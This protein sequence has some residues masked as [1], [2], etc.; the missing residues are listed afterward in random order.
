MPST[1]GT[2]DDVNPDRL[3]ALAELQGL[4][5]PATGLRLLEL[6]REVPK[7]HAIV[8]L[9]A[10]K[11]KSTC[12]LAEGAR[13]GNGAHVF[14]IDAWDLPTNLRGKHGY[15]D[16][17]TYRRY[18][19]QIADMELGAYITTIQA[20][21]YAPAEGW[22]QPVGLL[23]IDASHEFKDVRHDYLSWERHV[24]DGGIVAFDDYATRRNPG[25]TKWVDH[26]VRHD[27]TMHFWDT[28]TLPLAIARKRR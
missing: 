28:R 2:T 25:V 11:G 4:I 13:L 15:T 16:P 9:G 23:F 22:G 19:Q 6:A 20:L 14:S 8:E 12:Y 26:L 17:E 21:S 5:A 24:V 10:F 1:I 18:L 27:A 3:S 7:H